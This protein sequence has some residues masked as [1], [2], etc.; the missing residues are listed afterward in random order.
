MLSRSLLLTHS[1]LNLPIFKLV[2][3]LNN[4]SKGSKN[5]EYSIAFGGIAKFNALY[6]STFKKLK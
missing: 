1:S 6:D 3:S 5:S 4:I 2:I